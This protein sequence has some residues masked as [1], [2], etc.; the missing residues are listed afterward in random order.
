[1][2]FFGRARE[3]ALL[4]AGLE[5]ARHGRGATFLLA[6]PPGIGKTR[7]AEE[8]T[9]DTRVVWGRAWE[10]GGAPPCWPWLEALRALAGDDA[11]AE[12]LV[13]GAEVTKEGAQAA[14]F[15]R[16]EAVV[17]FLAAATRAGPL[18]LILDDLHAADEA[19][20]ELLAFVARASRRLPLLLLGTFRSTEV[21]PDE[22]RG[23][24]LHRAAREG[25]LL[26]I[27]PL[28]AD[29]VRGFVVSH[30]N[31]EAAARLV[32]RAEGHPLYLKELLARPS[33]DEQR[34]PRGLE[35]ALAEHLGTV[36]LSTREV[37]GAAAVVGRAVTVTEL[38]AVA[39]TTPVVA[40]QALRRGEQ[41]GIVVTD[42]NTARFSHGLLRDALARE[43]PEADR[44]ERHWR[45]AS[46]LAQQQGDARASE[47]AH[48]LGLARD[49]SAERD[50]AAHAASLQAAD[51]ARRQLAFTEVARYLAAAVATVPAGAKPRVAAE[52]LLEQ[53]I[54]WLAAGHVQRGKDLCAQVIR[55]ARALG[56]TDLEA[57]AAL[58]YGAVFDFGLRDVSLAP[59]L[60]DALASLGEGETA[61][62][63]RL[64]ARL[65]AALNM[66]DPATSATLGERALRLA[67]QH[68]DR[69]LVEVLHV[70]KFSRHVW[71]L[72]PEERSALVGELAVLAG[73][74]GNTH[75]QA[76]ALG[77]LI[78]D[79]LAQGE[80]ATARRFAFELRALV[81][82]CRD[83]QFLVQL[84]VIDACLACLVGDFAALPALLREA[85]AMQEQVALGAP[86]S[87]FITFGACLARRDLEELARSG[88]TSA[89]IGGPGAPL[90][91]A[92]VAGSLGELASARA[93]VLMP[94][95]PITALIMLQAELAIL[96]AEPRPLEELERLLAATQ[97]P[98]GLIGPNCYAGPVA[99]V[100]ALI[101]AYRGDRPRARE[102]F[103]T[104]LADC[105]RAGALPFLARTRVEFA[106]FL[107]D[108]DGTALADEGAKLARELKMDAL[109]AEAQAVLA[110]LAAKP[111]APVAPVTSDVL[112]LERHGADWLLRRGATSVPVRD[113]KGVHY[114]GLL[115]A[116]PGRDF[117]VAELAIEEGD[118]GDG[119]EMLD[120]KA[121]EAYRRRIES[122]RDELG[123]AE[124]WHD[125]TRA[126]KLRAELESLAGELARAVGLGGRDR[127][128]ASR[129]ERARINVQR[130]LQ[131]VIDQVTKLDPRLGR[132]LKNSVKSGTYCRYE[133]D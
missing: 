42:D 75:V 53:G 128:A 96:C 25:A 31:V 95:S 51:A 1:M 113:G 33:S 24:L 112:T 60:R 43:L 56:D 15:R 124:R 22:P 81:G 49:G 111:A 105:E 101:A 119:G 127:R 44:R 58:G 99:R 89:Q 121:K 52:L 27:G 65:S 78:H 61:L 12:I 76:H 13:G 39:G 28:A 77:M 34:W 3:M 129:L 66:S 85:E 16:C 87:P 84:P 122:L 82:R 80:T 11:P 79:A 93:L 88:S 64:L 10:G 40:E 69:V 9:R 30:A 108:A 62:H 133:P 7:L 67:R 46:S 6:G 102:L 18:A 109:F 103:T 125:G 90:A 70:A 63:A 130:R 104:A 38:A 123:E 48:H 57:R 106:R 116:H 8:V 35:S 20:I 72:P 4:L 86:W 120:A 110:Q 74:L 107:G 26:T 92:W 32:E 83:T 100:R 117:H 73:R 41:A 54:A 118:Q 91:K 97:Q 55:T 59:Y 37:L 17:A 45:L 115:M 21:S 2:K 47:I 114:L 98:H 50:A 14:R 131:H 29:D 132:A 19:T 36:D 5:E 126:T 68:D 94:P 71:D 23:Q